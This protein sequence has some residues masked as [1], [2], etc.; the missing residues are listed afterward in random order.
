MR[1]PLFV[2]AFIHLFLEKYQGG[3]A[4]KRALAIVPHFLFMTY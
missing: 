1:H 2:F 3:T 4:S